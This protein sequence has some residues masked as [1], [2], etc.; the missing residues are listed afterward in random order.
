M[1]IGYARV[2]TRDQDPDLQF[3]DLRKAG[4]EEIFEEKVSGSKRAGE[5]VALTQAMRHCREGDVLVVWKLDRLG[6][7]LRDLIDIAS[8]LR[9]RG[10]GFKSLQEDLDT[11]TSGGKLVFHVFGALAEW[12]RDV[13]RERTHA[14]LAAARSRGKKGGRPKA[15]D[16]SKVRM[17]H[18]LMADKRNSVNDVCK[19]LGV[20]RSTLYKYL[21]EGDSSNNG[22]PGSSQT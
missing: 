10:V 19:T 16:K 3:Q 5:R 11:T 4:C 20:S 6:R 8:G 18:S 15:M 9:E 21:R 17:A 2:S 14:G 12:E 1:H 22:H 13:I 7:S